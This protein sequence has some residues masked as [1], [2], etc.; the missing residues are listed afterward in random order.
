MLALTA[1]AC[2]NKKVLVPPME[3]KDALPADTEVASMDATVMGMDAD[4]VD[5]GVM[6]MDAEAM[7]AL[8]TGELVPDPGDTTITEWKDIEPNDTPDHA[9]PQGPLAGP[10]W[11]GFSAPNTTIDNNTDVDYFVFKTTA[12]LSQVYIEICWG[13]AGNLLD[14]FLYRVDA[15]RKGPQVLAANETTGQCERLVPIGMGA[16]LLMPNTT[17]LLEVRA[18][19]GLMLNGASGGYSA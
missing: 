4:I 10:V 6:G 19:P 3:G 13:F 2:E 7:D 14:L 18:G 8:A 5:T 16:T 15:G 17:Y 1:W 12:D 11:A 9:V